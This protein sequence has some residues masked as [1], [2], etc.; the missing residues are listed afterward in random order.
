MLPELVEGIIHGRIS[1]H[2]GTRLATL[3][4]CLKG[5]NKQGEG[6]FG[7]PLAEIVIGKRFA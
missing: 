2:F 7:L 3:E 5:I 4:G 6:P 1:S